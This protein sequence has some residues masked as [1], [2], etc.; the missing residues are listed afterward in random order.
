[1]VKH[2]AK[3]VRSP[4]GRCVLW[5]LSV[6]IVIVSGS[7]YYWTWLSGN[8]S[9]SD[10]IRNLV[11]VTVSIIGLPLVFWR[12]LVAERQVETSRLT[13]ANERFQKGAEMLSA[14][15]LHEQRLSCPDVRESE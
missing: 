13:L 4:I 10:T 3:M 11:L 2:I 5:T 1:M 14:Q 6:A 15:D 9:P 12:S 7:T 8:G